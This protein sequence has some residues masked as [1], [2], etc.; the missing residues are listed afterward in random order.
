VSS[1]LDALSRL[2]TI[3]KSL[4]KASCELFVK[5]ICLLSLC[6]V[7]KS[8]H[9][10][11][12]SPFRAIA[13]L[14]NFCQVLS[15][16][17]CSGFWERNFFFTEQSR[18]LCVNPLRGWWGLCSL[19]AVFYD[20]QVYRWGI[21]MLLHK[22]SDWKYRTL[23]PRIFRFLLKSLLCNSVHYVY[24]EAACSSCRVAPEVPGCLLVLQHW[25]ASP[26]FAGINN[27]V[28]LQLIS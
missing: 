11:Q 8:H 21:L 4:R 28:F 10:W 12:N 25:S 18:Q 22:G 19:F 7:I 3:T 6:T 16:F 23:I 2:R 15:G 17:R 20:S 14:R 5:N 1:L 13:F 9:H 27:F 26:V 24:F